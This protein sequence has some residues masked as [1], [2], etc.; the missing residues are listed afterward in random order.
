MPCEHFKTPGGFAILCT[1]G[2]P[3]K[4]CY[5]CNRLGARYQ[6]DGPAPE[7]KSGTCDRYVCGQCATPD[8][9]KRDYCRDHAAL[10]LSGVK[11]V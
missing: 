10:R 3:R 9:P 2:A 8:G 1:R 5:H 11:D 6:C 7:R 4:R